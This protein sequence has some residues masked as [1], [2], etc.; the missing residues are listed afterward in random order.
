MLLD[1][2]NIKVK[3]EIVMFRYMHMK[4]NYLFHMNDKKF[5]KISK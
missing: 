5:D 1:D 2:S 4:R 3:H